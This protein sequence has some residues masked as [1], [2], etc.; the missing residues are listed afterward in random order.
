MPKENQAILAFNRGILSLLGSARADLARYKM[1]AEVMTNWVARVLGSMMLRVGLEYTGATKSNAKSRNLPFV[2][3]V[4]DVAQLEISE[5]VLRIWI[6]DVLITRPAVTAVVTNGSFTSN[7]T[8]WTDSDESGATSQWL[9]G[10]YLSLAGTGTNAAIRDQQVTVNEANVEHALRIVIARGPVVC[11]IGSTSGGDEYV[12]ETTLGTG[13]HSLSFIP[14]GNFYIRVSNARI[15]VSL[16]DSI[17]VESAGTLELPA[18]WQEEDLSLL[19]I[20]QSGDILFVACAGTQQHQIERR[21][22]APNAR[23][24]SVVLYQPEDGPFRVMNKTPIT[25]TPSAVSGDIT[26]MANK[27]LFKAVQVGALF[28]IPSTGQLVTTSLTG[29]DQFTDSIRVAGI[30]TQRNFQITITG[31]WVATVTL[32]YSVGAPG[33]WV[34]VKSWTGNTTETYNDTLDNQ[35]IYYRIGI[36]AADYTSGTAVAT[37]SFASG[38][39]TGIVR[40]TGYT[41]PT[42]VSAAVLKALGGTS[43]SADWSEGAWSDYRGWPSAVSLHEGG[44]WWPGKD[45]IQGS[46]SDGYS[47]FDDEIEGDSGPISR[48]IGEGPIDSIHWALSLRRMIL[49]TASNSANIAAVRVEGN[50]PIAALSDAF[51]EPLTPTN[52]NLKYTSTKGIFVDRSA[53]RLYEIAFDASAADYQTDDISILVPDLNEAGI[54]QIAIQHK[55]DVRLHCVRADGTV[56]LLVFD[57]AENVVCWAELET[58]GIIEDVCVLPGAGEDQVYYIVQRTINGATVRYREKWALESECTGFPDAHHADA[59]YRYSGAATTTITG[60]SHLEGETVVVWGW[61]TITPFTDVDGNA[62][63]R[64]FGTFTVSSGQIAGLSAAVT[65]ACVGLAYEAPWKSMKQAFAA[66]MGTPL[67][68]MKRIDR[69]GLVL[70]NAHGQGLQYGPDFN[71]LDDLPQADLPD[72]AGVPDTNHIYSTYDGDMVSLAGTWDT[73]ARLCLKAAAPRPCTVL[74]AVVSMQTSG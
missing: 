35:I 57:R 37:L 29:A 40:I 23:S 24:W 43:G 46:V 74:A 69:V 18:P 48:S 21:G 55:P 72:T 19:R 36:K 32:Q 20:V 49:G 70:L 45:K 26:V 52:F 68:Q 62:I 58:D 71:N 44:L 30:T 65:N 1:A 14:T 10:G 50:N 22:I 3:S 31:T 53:Q 15:P 41:S 61:N 73:D 67:N 6:D 42:S 16:V 56:G 60:L 34:D 11:R 54:V 59:F 5:N 17:T 39:I 47:T 64:D 8:S 25:L 63:G 33:S 4:D 13:T 12:T 66:G 38:S 51:D 28:K 7:V 27:T 9:T 2:F